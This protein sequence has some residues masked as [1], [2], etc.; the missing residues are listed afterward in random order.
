MRYML[1]VDVGGTFTDLTLVHVDSTTAVSHKVRSTPDDPARAIMTGVREIL[2]RERIALEEV[3][4]FAHGTTVATN[5]LIERKG[6][7]T[8]LLTTRGFRDLLEIRDQTRP[9]LYDLSMQAPE[10][11]VEPEHRIE[12][13]ERVGADGGTVVPLNDEDVDAAL[14]RLERIDPAGIA[15]CFLFSFQNAEHERRIAE[16]VRER[17]P[18]AFVTTSSDVVPE[19]REYPRLSTT[20]LNAYLG[21]VVQSYL[22]RLEASVVEDGLG[23]A[24]YVT[25]SNGGVLSIGETIAAPIRTAISGP[26]AGVV[27][28][29]HIGAAIGH[30]NLI[31]F[32]MGGTSADISLIEDGIPIV[33]M[34]RKV[35][36]WPVRI[37]MLDIVTIG[38]GGG[39]I[40]SID[41][42]GALKVG[43]RS[44]GASPGPACYGNGGE[45]ATVT[46]ANAV[47]GRVSPNGILG[48]AMSLDVSA[49]TEAVQ[50]TVAR[51]MGADVQ[52]AADGIV[53]VVNAAMVR[54]IRGVSVARGHDPADFALMAFGGAGPLHAAELVDDLDI[55]TVIVPP[56]AGTFCS[57]GLMVADIRSDHVRSERIQ[58]NRVEDKGQI[59]TY[60]MALLEEGRT[61]LEK[62]GVPE[63][64]RS[65]ELTAEA[66]YRR[67]NYELP[68]SMLVQEIADEEDI[69]SLVTA[70]F[71]DQHR[72]LYGHVSDDADVEVVNLR[73]TAIGTLP[74]PSIRKQPATS[75]RAPTPTGYRVVHFPRTLGPVDCP[76]FDR[77]SLASGDRLRGP[78]VIEQLDATTLLPPNRDLEVDPLGNLI[79]TRSIGAEEL[80]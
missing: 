13:D 71:Q 54:A 51:R 9:S 6:R 73:V 62:E 26:S 52:A 46:D 12:I 11:F 53:R 7:R 74:K 22:K 5:A 10:P 56:S 69:E 4:Y 31:T 36:G 35:D 19:F 42:G 27:A 15:I 3:G 58:P 49:A 47:L 23:V 39:S 30:K 60:F 41:A 63:H 50:R 16:R 70:R 8:A 61:V 66:R 32:D 64:A 28:A 33:S 37:P 72:H 21:P 1:G 17:V 2:E 20:V 75:G 45:D 24:P 80:T 38:A 76:V 29:A 59:W 78:A 65:Y 44:A 77:S 43:P 67:Q 14:E 48:G 18:G 34:E 68:V 79:L 57:Y 40:A 55:P 25:Q